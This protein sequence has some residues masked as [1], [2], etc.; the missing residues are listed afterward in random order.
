VQPINYG[1]L[2]DGNLGFNVSHPQ[3]WSSPG[4]QGE[5]ERMNALVL[6]VVACYLGSFSAEYGPG[7]LKNHEMVHCTHGLLL[8]SLYPEAAR[9]GA[10]VT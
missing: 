6:G 10:L 4:W 1:H 3:G 7:K 9:S 5:G 2:G 8:A